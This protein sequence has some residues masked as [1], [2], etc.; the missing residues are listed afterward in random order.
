MDAATI[1]VGLLLLVVLAALT[2]LTNPPSAWIGRRK[3]SGD[4]KPGK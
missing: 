2:F 1:V 3:D 4:D